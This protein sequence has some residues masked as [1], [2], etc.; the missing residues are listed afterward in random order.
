MPKDVTVTVP[1]VRLTTDQCSDFVSIR[2]DILCDT[3]KNSGISCSFSYIN[4]IGQFDLNNNCCS[5]LPQVWYTPG[6]QHV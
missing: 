3:H 5:G 2:A 4:Y 1:G 6:G